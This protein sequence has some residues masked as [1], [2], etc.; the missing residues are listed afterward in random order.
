M[1]KAMKKISVCFLVSA[2]V[3]S[4]LTGCAKK[5]KCYICAKEL[6][7][8]FYSIDIE[9]YDTEEYWMC[10]NCSDFVRGGVETLNGTMTKKK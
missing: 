3:L 10:D 6:W 7:C 8:H 9:G 1:R 4:S 5:T 2:L